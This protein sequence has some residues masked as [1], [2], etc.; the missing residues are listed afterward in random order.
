MTVHLEELVLLHNTPC[1][2]QEVVELTKN[3]LY[4]HPISSGLFFGTQRLYINTKLRH[5]QERLAGNTCTHKYLTMALLHRVDFVY[6]V[7]LQPLDWIEN[8]DQQDIGQFLKLCAFGYRYQKILLSK[9]IDDKTLDHLMSLVDSS[10]RMRYCIDFLKLFD[11]QQ[12]VRVKIIHSL[13]NFQHRCNTYPELAFF[14]RRYYSPDLCRYVKEH[15]DLTSQYITSQGL[16]DIFFII[17]RT[18][19]DDLGDMAELIVQMRLWKT[20][21]VVIDNH[22]Q[23]LLRL[24]IVDE[25]CRSNSFAETSMVLE[26]VARLIPT[27]YIPTFVA[28]IKQYTSVNFDRI[29]TILHDRGYRDEELFVKACKY[30][31]SDEHWVEFFHTYAKLYRDQYIQNLYWTRTLVALQRYKDNN[32]TLALQTLLMVDHPKLYEKVLQMGMYDILKWFRWDSA[33]EPTLRILEKK[34][35][36]LPTRRNKLLVSRL[37][38]FVGGQH[39]QLALSVL[40]H[41]VH[42]VEQIKLDKLLPL[43]EHIPLARTLLAKPHAHHHE[44]AEELTES[45]EFECCFYEHTNV[46]LVPKAPNE[47]L[48]VVPR[49]CIIRCPAVLIYD[50]SPMVRKLYK[51]QQ[52]TTLIIPDNKKYDHLTLNWWNAYFV[53]LTTGKLNLTQTPP[54]EFADTSFLTLD[55]HLVKFHTI[56]LQGDFFKRFKQQPHPFHHSRDVLEVFLKMMN[57]SVDLTFKT[58]DMLV[59]LLIAFDFYLLPFQKELVEAS[60]CKRVTKENSKDLLHIAT[61]YN[62]PALETTCRIISKK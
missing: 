15:I 61:L 55:N 32:L 36:L 29:F 31:T 2:T 17:V 10:S 26:K 27:E 46:E 8:L 9:P 14:L 11:H 38:Y 48:L 35:E 42:D 39:T 6:D 3:H 60:L 44:A 7:G 12:N 62:C 57:Y 45:N 24:N 41:I 54:E 50:K 25:L 19:R 4:E 23:E 16:D 37:F 5:L 30:S 34:H 49:R 40:C 52:S 43:V 47:I 56:L 58:F 21:N 1:L 13:V 22:L 33:V 28:T 51:E 53:K 18:I 20:A 59:E